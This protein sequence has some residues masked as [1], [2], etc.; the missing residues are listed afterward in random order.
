[1]TV[2]DSTSAAGAASPSPSVYVNETAKLIKEFVAITGL[3]AAISRNMLVERVFTPLVASKGASDPGAVLLSVT[4]EDTAYISLLKEWIPSFSGR[5]DGVLPPAAP[6]A[7]SLLVAALPL[8]AGGIVWS[9]VGVKVAG[10]GL[11]ADALKAA[12]AEK[13]YMFGV[14]ALPGVALDPAISEGAV[15]I[16]FGDP[17]LALQALA[18]AVETAKNLDEVLRL[19]GSLSAPVEEE[20]EQNPPAEPE[21]DVIPES[22]EEVTDESK[23]ETQPVDQDVEDEDIEEDDPLIPAYTQRVMDVYRDLFEV[24]FEL[25]RPFGILT[26]RGILTLR[27]GVSKLNESAGYAPLFDLLNANGG[28]LLQEGGSI[29]GVPASELRDLQLRSDATYYPAFH[30]GNLF[31][32]MGDLRVDTWDQLEPLLTKEVYNNIKKNKEAGRDID[33]IVNALTNCIV[34]TDFN[35][36]KGI[37]LRANIGNRLMNKDKL[38][39]EY[40]QVRTTIFAGNGDLYHIDQTKTGVLELSLVFNLKAFT[41]SPLFAY[42]AVEVQLNRGRKPSLNSMILG[43]NTSGKIV[44]MNMNRQNASV[45]LIG[46][47]PRSGK[48]VLTLNLLGT[49]LSEGSPLI[50]LDGKPDMAS[51]I[52]D[53]GAKVGQ[54]PAAWD[55]M[56]S[57]GYPVGQGAPERMQRENPGLFGALMYYKVVQLMIAAAHLRA[58]DVPLGNGKRPFFIFDEALAVQMLASGVWSNVVKMSKNKAEPEDMEWAKHI[59]DWCASVAASLNGALV[60]QLPKSG[61]STVWLFQS[62]QRTTWSQYDLDGNAGKFNVLSSPVKATA[63]IKFMGRGTADTEYGLTNVKNDR[64]IASR[65]MDEGGRHFALSTSQKI[66]SMEDVTIFKPYLVLNEHEADAK[67]VIEMRNNVGPEVWAAITD[68]R[69]NLHPGAGFPGFA[70]MLGEDA[71]QNLGLGRAYLEELMQ[72]LGLNYSTVEEYLY[73]ASVESFKTVGELTHSGSAD[74]DMDA[75]E[76]ES[77]RGE[78]E[79]ESTGGYE[80]GDSTP[81]EELSA[82]APVPAPAPI[83]SPDEGAAPLDWGSRSYDEPAPAPVSEESSGPDA[84]EYPPG[85]GPDEEGIDSPGSSAPSAEPTYETERLGAYTPPPSVG[86]FAGPSGAAGGPA[87]SPVVNR[88]QTDRVESPNERMGYSNVYTKE[89]DLDRDAFAA[90]KRARGTFSSLQAIRD[91]SNML[92]EEIAE[93]FG[94]LSRVS[95]IEVT[96]TGL[97]INGV[98]FRPRFSQE[99]IAA[100]PYDIQG[101]V[102]R[103]NIIELFSFSNLY[104]FRN[105]N[106]LIVDNARIAEGRMRRELG[107]AP[108]RPWSFLLRKMSSLTRLE[109]AGEVITDETSARQYDDNGRGG[110]TL[111]D[112][113]RQGLGVSE[114]LVNPSRISGLLSKAWETRPVRIVGRAAGWT[115]AAYTVTT[116]AGAIG[117]WGG[118]LAGAAAIFGFREL[119][120]R[121]D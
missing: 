34:V 59:M 103:G 29:A 31:G 58:N 12:L 75:G 109:I 48:G 108:T 7:R 19:S 33:T 54:N 77:D 121:R 55:G 62:M 47:G 105:L 82:G 37:Q 36:K 92:M 13:G 94:D 100:M 74:A 88:M 16:E 68:E 46:A 8:A 43:Q 17:K 44:T 51:V 64:M 69:G 30:L 70:Q 91:T 102:A 3:N 40:A 56:T 104:K 57:Y 84:E 67:S 27:K 9:W 72:K 79:L 20:T 21:S 25:K 87:P 28:G 111:T 106:T 114:R 45:I 118:V 4:S 112:R 1:M 2:V 23:S 113:L 66:A 53:L 95:A 18:G 42:E 90:H 11:T 97:A 117:L 49:I 83:W 38:T 26:R 60:S 22:E 35:P 24:G 52:R 86:G 89:V 5:L 32:V 6:D 63:S 107:I 85:M 14:G 93:A 39:R 99:S 10:A 115:A 96:G 80:S 71:V 15:L 120:K 50:Y 73:D 78:Q 41:G 110:V 65:V 61:I 76:Y 101:Q 116:V 119:R 98:A 81:D